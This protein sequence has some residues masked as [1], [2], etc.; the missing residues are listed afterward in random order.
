MYVRKDDRTV[1]RDFIIQKKKILDYVDAALLLKQFRNVDINVLESSPATN[2]SILGI[3][4]VGNQA[5]VMIRTKCNICSIID[6][7]LTY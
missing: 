4:G 3:V 5:P 1:A 7:I 2:F 6:R